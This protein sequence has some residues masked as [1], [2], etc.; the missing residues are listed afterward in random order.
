MEMK[1]V[2][3]QFKLRYHCGKIKVFKPKYKFYRY[4][5]KNFQIIPIQAGNRN[6]EKNSLFF[7]IKLRFN[8]VYN[9]AKGLNMCLKK[10][11]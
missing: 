8:G 3:D 9:L 6:L 4:L 11:W 7:H 2:V 10:K 1:V 5:T